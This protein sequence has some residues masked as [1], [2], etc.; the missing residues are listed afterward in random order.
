MA[1]TPTNPV[2]TMDSNV[3]VAPIAPTE[4]EVKIG[5]KTLKTDTATAAAIKAAQDAATAAGNLVETN[6]ALQKQIDDLKKAAPPQPASNPD[7]YTDLFLDP[8]G[9]LTRFA[10]TL[11]ANIVAE[12]RGEAAQ[13]TAQTQ[14]WTEFYNENK[15]L[16]DADVFVKAVLTRD[17]DSLKSMKVSEV[18]KTLAESTRAEILKLSPKGGHGKPLA[19]GGT[20]TRK[21][22]SKEKTDESEPLPTTSISGVIAERKAARRKAATNAQ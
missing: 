6:K 11:K 13:A 8:K 21:P 1:D 17:Y 15:D 19:E 12:V 4:V 2:V 3:N 18:I 9:F 20:E 14:F 16:K 10:Q 5:D 7:E 22:G